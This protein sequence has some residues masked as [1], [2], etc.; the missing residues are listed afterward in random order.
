[1]MEYKRYDMKYYN[2]HIIKTKKFKTI[3][4]RV[5]FK[6]KLEK[7]QI[8]IR[9]FLNDLLI[10]SSNKYPT[11]RDIV[12][13]TE[14]LYDI[15]VKTSPYKSGNFSIMSFHSVFLNE[16]YTEKGINKKSIEF[17]MELIFNP[18]IKNNKFDNNYFDIIKTS[19]KNNIESIKDNPSKYS[20]VR[21][22]EEMDEGPVSYHSAGYMEDLNKINPSNLFD[23]YKSVI[24][25]DCIDVFVIGDIKEEEIKNI[26]DSYIPKT[27]K[28]NE[29]I[30]H[31]LDLK[32]INN[33]EIKEQF[34]INQSKLAIGLK[35]LDLTDFE[36][37]YVL[38]IYSSI[39]GGGADSKLFKVVR[40]KNSLCYYIGSTPS[41]IANIIT[42]VAGINSTDYEKAKTLIMEEFEKI[43]NGD[44]EEEDIEK[45]IV[46]YI[47]GCKEIYDTPSAIISNYLSHE[48][49]D[50]DL[51]E[52]KIEKVKKVTKGDIIELAK[53]TVFDTIYILEGGN[54][55]E[56]NTSI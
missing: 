35:A 41:V 56:K 3:N 13:E 32:N 38:S 27:I 48:Y 1:M 18:D 28:N 53:K 30:S 16:K 14:E 31:F 46:T 52:E 45:A 12:I 2:L 20:L 7:D 4:I 37:K 6:R 10:N 40:E 42:I 55:I 47:N 29:S 51:I 50:I 34:D 17:L 21:L 22:Y 44:F 36:R 26:L 54:N 5:N 39:L 8:T 23:Y 33:K 11:S 19:L 25:N 43:K 24:E 9:N 49:A 15:G